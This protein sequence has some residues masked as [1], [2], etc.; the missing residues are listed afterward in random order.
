MIYYKKQ[1]LNMGIKG[2]ESLVFGGFRPVFR[3]QR[4]FNRGVFT[5]L[6]A[7]TPR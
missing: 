5:L 1:L 4:L 3:L 2:I 7:L 6:F